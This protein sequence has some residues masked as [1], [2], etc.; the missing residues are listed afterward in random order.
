MNR[1]EDDVDESNAEEENV[2]TMIHIHVHGTKFRIIDQSP[3]IPA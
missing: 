2:G 3:G 1:L